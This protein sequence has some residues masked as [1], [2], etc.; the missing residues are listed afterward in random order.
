[1]S[2]IDMAK[3]L[4]RHSNKV[5]WDS[6]VVIL[7]VDKPLSREAEEAKRKLEAFRSAMYRWSD[8]RGYG[9]KKPLDGLALAVYE[10]R[11]LPHLKELETEYWDARHSA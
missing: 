11:A 3:K 8:L 9:E 5:R 4:F 2:L 6:K 7:V 1:M 10:K